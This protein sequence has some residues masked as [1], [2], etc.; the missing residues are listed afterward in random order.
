MDEITLN[1]LFFKLNLLVDKITNLEYKMDLMN[2]H[3]KW[4]HSKSKE[5]TFPTCIIQSSNYYYIQIFIF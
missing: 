1:S 4:K 2:S 5:F 3:L